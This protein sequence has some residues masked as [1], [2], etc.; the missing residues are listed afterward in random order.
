MVTK[1][2]INNIHTKWSQINIYISTKR[3][4]NKCYPSPFSY[5]LHH[6]FSTL[7]YYYIYFFTEI[8]K[9]RLNK[10]ANYYLLYFVNH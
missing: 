2:Y 3:K 6:H 8:L 5:N 1:K 9:P 10:V 7:L 4:Y